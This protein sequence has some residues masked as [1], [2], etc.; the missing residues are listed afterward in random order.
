MATKA[1]SELEKNA[2]KTRQRTK[3]RISRK[4]SIIESTPPMR[5]LTLY[6]SWIRDY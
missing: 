5:P 4:Y 1:T 2:E 6:G 3:S